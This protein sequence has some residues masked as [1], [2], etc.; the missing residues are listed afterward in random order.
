MKEMVTVGTLH[1]VDVPK[2][3]LDCLRDRYR[4]RPQQFLRAMMELPGLFTLEQIASSSV[5]GKK[6]ST[7]P[8]DVRPALG[9]KFLALKGNYCMPFPS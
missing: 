3:M 6:T 4:L 2:A 7:S 1:K 8:D 9:P 5:Y